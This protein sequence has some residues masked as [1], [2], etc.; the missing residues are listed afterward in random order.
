MQ[1]E[2]DCFVNVLEVVGVIGMMV[3]IFKFEAMRD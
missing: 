3:G 1:Y 2:F